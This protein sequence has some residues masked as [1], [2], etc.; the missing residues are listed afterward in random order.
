MIS[1]FPMTYSAKIEALLNH[2]DKL[3]K[4]ICPAGCLRADWSDWSPWWKWNCLIFQDIQRGWQMSQVNITQLLG[5][6]FQQKV[7]SNPWLKQ[8][9][10]MKTEQKI[11]EWRSIRALKIVLVTLLIYFKPDFQG[12]LLRAE[13]GDLAKRNS[14]D[15]PFFFQPGMG[16]AAEAWS[17]RGA[18]RRDGIRSGRK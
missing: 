9:F 17:K 14:A 11:R 4:L 3:W 16:P 12:S 18:F 7:M 8:D 1:H 5:I 15:R 6:C 10:M 13:L 2:V